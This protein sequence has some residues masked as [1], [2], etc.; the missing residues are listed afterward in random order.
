M[1]DET[2][3]GAR[4]DLLPRSFDDPEVLAAL[5]SDG[6]VYAMQADGVSE[7]RVESWSVSLLTNST[8]EKKPQSKLKK[9]K[10]KLLHESPTN[11]E[12]GEWRSRI[13]R[14]LI[15][16]RW[17]CRDCSHETQVVYFLWQERRCPECWSLNMEILESRVVPSRSEKFGNIGELFPSMESMS[18]KTAANHIWGRSPVDDAK[19]LVE[20]FV[21]YRKAPNGHTYLYVLLLFARTLLPTRDKMD[22]DSFNLLLNVGNIAQNYFRLT[23]SYEGARAMIEYFE[24]ASTLDSDPV[25]ITL[26]KHSFG[27]A[28]IYLLDAYNEPHAELITERPG[29]RQTAIA[30]LRDALSLVEEILERDPERGA[31]QRSRIRYALADLLRAGLATEAERAEALAIF[32]DLTAAEMGSLS[33]AVRAARAQTLLAT[34]LPSEDSEEAYRPYAEAIKELYDLIYGPNTFK[35]RF[36]WRWALAVGQHLLRAGLRDTAAQYLESSVTFVQKD[37][38][39]RSDPLTVTSDSEL[40]HQSFSVLAGLYT[41]RG[42]WFEALALLETYRGRALELATLSATERRGLE[43]HAE[44]R[45]SNE[46]FGMFGPDDSAGLI[47][48]E[49]QATG[50]AFGPFKDDFA[51]PGLEERLRELFNQS[52]DEHTVLVSLSIDDTTFPP[53]QVISAILL[54]AKTKKAADGRVKL[55]HLSREQIQRLTSDFYTRQST[56]REERLQQLGDLIFEHLIK[57]IEEELRFFACR[58]VIMVTP[59]RL[60]NLPFEAYRMSAASAETEPLPTHFVFMPSLMFGRSG[61]PATPRHGEEKLLIIGYDGADLPDADRE[62]ELIGGLFGSRA[63]YISGR[64]CTKKRVTEALRGAYDYI[65]FICHGTYDAQHPGESALYFRDLWTADAYRLRARELRDLVRFM[66]RPVVTLSACSTALTADSRSN[67]WHGLPGSLLEVGAHCIIGTRWAVED[68]VAR[69]HMAEFYQ[70]VLSTDKTPL[71]SFFTMQDRAR[72][73]RPMQEW[74]CFGY[75][76]LP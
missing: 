9:I 48:A 28:V 72:S 4:S 74:S 23:G 55:W 70:Q 32:G 26:A 41:S 6:Q 27:M 52:S 8:S 64:E 56:W 35:L 11:D 17:R 69:T 40:Y 75:L 67:T 71:Q 54:S 49:E 47:V 16:E 10:N 58:R 73:H 18:M 24:Q 62:A 60:S 30:N 45:R 3:L 20:R 44:K 42:W 7:S 66:N 53:D 29:L 15:Q 61:K 34:D 65:H 31:R 36:R 2:I 14:H 12:A 57:P 19:A 37:T 38:S 33:T 50:I 22:Q 25:P 46:F 5:S 59:S 13:V 76:G 1:P 51:L 63:S 43:F 39:F 21:T 68:S